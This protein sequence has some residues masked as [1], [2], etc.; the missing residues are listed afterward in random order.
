MAS[1]PCWVGA[2]HRPALTTLPR[3]QDAKPL[4]VYSVDFMVDNAQ[5]GFLG[6]RRAPGAPGLADFRGW[7]G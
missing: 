1:A 2:G 3:P 4:E 6:E 7:P 5:L